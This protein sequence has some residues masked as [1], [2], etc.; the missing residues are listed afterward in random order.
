MNLKAIVL[1][2]IIGLSGPAIADM[3]LNT[4]AFAQIYANE[5]TFTDSEWQVTIGYD[6]NAFSYYGVNLRTGNSIRL[7][8][9]KVSGNSQRR[10]YTWTNGDFRYQVAWQPSEPQIIRLQVFDGRG[11]EV[12]NRLLYNG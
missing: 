8:G 10:I 2:T 7:R 11:R 12:L 6:G 4:H 5:G 9:A 1:A 3:A